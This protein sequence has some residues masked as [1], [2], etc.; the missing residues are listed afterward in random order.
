MLEGVICDTC[1]QRHSVTA[2][3]CR[4]FTSSA[5]RYGNTRSPAGSGRPPPGGRDRVVLTSHRWTNPLSCLI[6]FFLVHSRQTVVFSGRTNRDRDRRLRR[7]QRRQDLSHRGSSPCC[8]TTSSASPQ[9]LLGWLRPVGGETMPEEKKI[10]RPQSREVEDG[11][12]F[13]RET[14]GRGGD[15]PAGQENRH[16]GLGSLTARGGAKDSTQQPPAQQS[17]QNGERN[18]TGQDKT[19]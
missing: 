2:E 17:Q 14:L 5:H 11:A 8:P 12:A 7:N 16:R 19:R 6:S 9:T 4:Q 18:E 13:S 15:S 1:R 3:Q 10:Y